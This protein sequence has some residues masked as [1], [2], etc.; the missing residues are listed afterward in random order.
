MKIVFYES[1]KTHLPI[2]NYYKKKT[3]KIT[4]HEL[5]LILEKKYNVVEN[6]CNKYEDKII[7]AIVN[8]LLQDD[9]KVFI[10]DNAVKNYWLDYIEN[11]EPA[12]Y[13]KR[14]IETN[15]VG[16]IDTGQYYLHMEPRLEDIREGIEEIL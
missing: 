5:A 13:S 12:I 15:T 14:A 6:F 1:E 9:P 7:T 8:E 16:L 4:I 10:I 2:S 3:S 11:G